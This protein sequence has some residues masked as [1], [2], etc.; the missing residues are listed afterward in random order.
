MTLTNDHAKTAADEV[1]GAAADK[2]AEIKGEN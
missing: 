1:V 2:A